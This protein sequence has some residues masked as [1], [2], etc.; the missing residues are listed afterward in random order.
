M[1]AINVISPYKHNG[2]WVFDDLRVGLVVSSKNIL[3]ARIAA[4]LQKV[5]VPSSKPISDMK[6]FTVV[7]G[8]RTL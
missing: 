3:A 7:E 6:S 8:G 4:K 2:M 1:N 5:T